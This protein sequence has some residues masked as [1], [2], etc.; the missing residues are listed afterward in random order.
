MDVLH[1]FRDYRVFLQALQ[2]PVGRN[3]APACSL[4][5]QK[6]MAWSISSLQC[7]LRSFLSRSSLLK[8]SIL[9]MNNPR[10]AEENYSKP[11]FS[12]CAVQ[13]LQVSRAA[14]LN[15]ICCQR[16][17]FY[18]QQNITL[19]SENGPRRL[20]CSVVSALVRRISVYKGC[21]SY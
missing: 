3:S 15:H 7:V 2:T 19:H 10:I 18:P 4:R 16:L 6:R 1:V 17:Q 21:S 5:T 14:P 8:P 13:P 20:V 11:R 9:L 12:E